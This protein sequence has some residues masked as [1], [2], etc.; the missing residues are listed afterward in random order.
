ME[1]NKENKVNTLEEMY[2]NMLF[3]SQ[4]SNQSYTNWEKV[5]DTYK[6][7]S[8]YDS[9]KYEIMLSTSIIINK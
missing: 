5:G 9:S 7:Y 2:N 6:K 4:S 8:I 3:S 1:L